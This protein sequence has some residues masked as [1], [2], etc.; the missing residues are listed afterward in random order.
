MV[1]DHD[2]FDTTLRIFELAYCEGDD[3]ALIAARDYCKEVGAEA[4]ADR[5]LAFWF[6]HH[7]ETVRAMESEERAEYLRFAREVCQI[8]YKE[9]CRQNGTSP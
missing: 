7:R 4:F 3:L 1:D 9:W 8:G 5:S 2:H 6:R